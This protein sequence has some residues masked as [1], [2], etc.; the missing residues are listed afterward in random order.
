MDV[1]IL[2]V[3]ESDE[4]IIGPVPSKAEEVETEPVESSSSPQSKPLH[5]REWDRGK[6][7]MC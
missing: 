6:E 1:F 7:G 3:D 2:L 4:E 5:I